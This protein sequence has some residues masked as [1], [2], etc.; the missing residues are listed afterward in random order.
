MCRPPWL[1]RRGCK[2]RRGQPFCHRSCAHPA[3]P[4]ATSQRSVAWNWVCGEGEPHSTCLPR[5]LEPISPRQRQA[6]RGIS[7][8]PAWPPPTPVAMIPWSGPG[9]AWE[10]SGS[11]AARSSRAEALTRRASP[12]AAPT[13]RSRPHILARRRTPCPRPF[14]TITAALFPP[15]RDLLRR[16]VQIPR[17]RKSAGNRALSTARRLL[18]PPPLRCPPLIRSR[19]ALAA[20]RDAVTGWR[21]GCRRPGRPNGAP[22][23]T[24]RRR[25][26]AFVGRG[27]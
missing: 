17:S 22:A 12:E 20:P 4:L 24:P 13:P 5:F 2:H 21:L 1:E 15:P 18:C 14:R 25:G 9:N 8:F 3:A 23:R 27:P 11:L 10:G 6:T 26:G 16:L 19:R 7:G